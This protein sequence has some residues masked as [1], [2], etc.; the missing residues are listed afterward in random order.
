MLWRG[1]RRTG[2]PHHRLNRSDGR[3]LIGTGRAL[4]EVMHDLDALDFTCL[5]VEVLVHECEDL[6]A[7]G[8]VRSSAAHETP[9]SLMTDDSSSG[10][11]RRNPRST[12]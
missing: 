9:S 4:L 2:P 6:G 11:G 3:V 12:A 7:R 10:S 5:P 1:C 8:G